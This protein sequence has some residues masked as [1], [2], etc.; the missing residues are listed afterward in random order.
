MDRIVIIGPPAAGKST[1]AARIADRFAVPHL[2][3]DAIAHGPG[4]ASTPPEQ[5]RTAL[6][7]R[8]E[9]GRWVSDG[10]YFDRAD[11]LWEQADTI[12]WLDL[13]LWVVVPRMVRR[14]LRR[15]LTKEELWNGNREQWS[16]LVGRDSLVLWA[17]KSQRIH[18]R[19]LP[20]RLAAL[21]CSGTAVVRL[22]SEGEV[23]RWWASM[24]AGDRATE[25]TP[26]V[27]RVPRVP[28]ALDEIG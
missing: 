16:A 14:S 20:Q 10:N 15:I 13:P 3:L 27:D 26:S 8:A 28:V 18:R 1:L 9:S 5:F 21:A 24:A 22:C 25:A 6:G 12:V 23:G 17:M 19:T 2:E 7:E 11:W 4:W